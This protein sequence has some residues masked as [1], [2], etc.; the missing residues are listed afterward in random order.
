MGTETTPAACADCG[1]ALDGP[2][3]SQCGQSAA[4]IRRP[5]RTLV[6]DFIGDTFV[7]DGRLWRTMKRL[8]INPGS[9]ARHYADGQRARWTPPIR[10]YLLVSLVFFAAMSLGGIRVLAAQILPSDETIRAQDENR[11]SERQAAV[12]V[13]LGRLEDRGLTI[14]PCG[15][16]P[17][18]Q[19]IEPDGVLRLSH[20]TG[21]VITLFQ[22]SEPP[23]PRRITQEDRRCLAAQNAASGLH[24]IFAELEIAALSDPAGFESRA[25]AATGQALILMVGFLAL[26]NLILH[27]RT[28]VIEHVIHSL[29]FHAAFLPVVA[30]S[31]G[32][33]QVTPGAPVSTVIIAAIAMIAVMIQVWRADR[34]FYRSSWYG[35]ALRLPVVAVGYLAALGVTSMGLILL[36]VL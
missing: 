2:Y 28:R 19:E 34:A 24:P 31:L 15:V 18:P 12:V 13:A 30:L 1:H 5:V 6:T 36:P 21:I 23:E 20:D 10:L 17:G 25:S 8:F 14:S 16:P 7:W 33:G 22:G 9:L 3:C 27:P 29:Y 26:L 11:I 35:A 32:V 4:D